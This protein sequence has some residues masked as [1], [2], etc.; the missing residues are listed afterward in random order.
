MSQ[1]EFHKMMRGGKG[2][3]QEQDKLYRDKVLEFGQIM[4]M[5]GH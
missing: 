5:S 3:Q 2:A 1:A 4:E